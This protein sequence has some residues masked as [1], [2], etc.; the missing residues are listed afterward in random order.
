MGGWY[1]GCIGEVVVWEKLS[2]YIDIWIKYE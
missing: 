2:V 1:E